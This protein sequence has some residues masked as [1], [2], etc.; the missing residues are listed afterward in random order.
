MK[1]CY[2]H[3]GW[4]EAVQRIWIWKPSDV[5][6]CGMKEE[7]TTTCLFM[8]TM[9]SCPDISMSF[10]VS[11]MRSICNATLVY[12]NEGIFSPLNCHLQWSLERK[13]LNKHTLHFHSDVEKRGAW[14]S[15]LMNRENHITSDF[16]D[17]QW[18]IHMTR[19][20]LYLI[21]TISNFIFVFYIHE[22]LC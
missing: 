8:E 5:K 7:E 22:T 10:S 12:S 16:H 17:I 9:I 2:A 21:W 15:Q 11:T 1:N 13:I 20:D 3:E 4:W 18:E 14:A 19:K 6:K